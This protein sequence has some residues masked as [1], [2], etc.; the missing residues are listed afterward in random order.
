MRVI[1]EDALIVCSHDGVV[2]LMPIQNWLTI[3][4]R[5]VLIENDPEGRSIALCPNI[6][7]TTKACLHTL[8]VEQGYSAFVRADGHSL[9][10]ETVQGKTDGLA[11]GK[12]FDYHVRQPGQDFVEG[13]A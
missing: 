3:N 8:K 9:C 6:S 7:T 11:P 12:V 4:G 13:S 1:T 5:K 2:Q 10:Y